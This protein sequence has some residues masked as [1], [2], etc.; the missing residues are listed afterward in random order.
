MSTLAQNREYKKRMEEFK[1]KLDELLTDYNVRISVND[2][3]DYYINTDIL[4]MFAE[5]EF[6]FDYSQPIKE[7][8]NKK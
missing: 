7:W 8:S 4:E 3:E 6:C 2:P 1:K 5:K